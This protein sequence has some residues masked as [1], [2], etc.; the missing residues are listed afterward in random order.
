V[1]GLALDGRVKVD[2]SGEVNEDKNLTDEVG[3]KPWEEHV[4][5]LSRK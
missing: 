1:S 2:C 3:E 5:E 4:K